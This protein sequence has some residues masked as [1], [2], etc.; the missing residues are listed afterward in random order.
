MQLARLRDAV[1]SHLE[2][3]ERRADPLRRGTRRLHAR[4]SLRSQRWPQGVQRIAK[5]LQLAVEPLQRHHEPALLFA[6]LVEMTVLR[7]PPCQGGRVIARAQRP[8]RGWWRQ[9]RRLGVCWR[10]LRRSRVG[11]RGLSGRRRGLLGNEE[12]CCAQAA[13]AQLRREP[14]ATARRAEDASGGGRRGGRRGGRSGGRSGE[15]GVSGSRS[16]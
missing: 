10:R 5:C 6:Q 16:G 14:A 9:R 2:L 13:G 4:L 3:C 15:R 7:T 1:T 8:R 12:P 11:G